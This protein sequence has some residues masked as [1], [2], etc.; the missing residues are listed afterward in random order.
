[1]NSA[2][3]NARRWPCLEFATINLDSREEIAKFIVALCDW[4]IQS[5]LGDSDVEQSP[6]PEALI[7]LLWGWDGAPK[8]RMAKL[9]WQFLVHNDS[10][11][12]FDQFFTI[13]VESISAQI[14]EA[15]AL[16][17]PIQ[18][19]LLWIIDGL[20][21]R[22][23]QDASIGQG[24]WGEEWWLPTDQASYVRQQLQRARPDLIEESS[25]Y[26]DS[27]RY[28][29]VPYF[30]LV[31]DDAERVYV[32]EIRPDGYEFVQVEDPAGSR[33][34]LTRA[35]LPFSQRP[36]TGFSWGYAGSGPCELATSILADAVGG[37]LLLAQRMR[38]DFV[39][40]VLA[41]I[42]Q[43][44]ALRIPRRDVFAWL[45]AKGVDS[46][47]LRE[48][49][50]RVA[51]L[52]ER[53]G[54]SLAEHKRRLALIRATGGLVAQRFDIV[55][56]DFECALYVDLMR[57][58]ENAGWV[59]RC[60]RCNQPLPCDRSPTGNRQRARWLA[61]RPVYHADCFT[62]HRREQKRA[63]WKQRTAIPS[64]RKQE[65]TRARNRRKSPNLEHF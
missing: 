28:Q 45:H 24:S 16:L 3:R 53:S 54:D 25:S 32:G 4:G 15:T 59:L 62:E 55:P 23:R 58:M 11:E 61:S 39:E 7:E 46:K 41:N 52:K 22:E 26:E 31:C 34:P 36:G 2:K 42:R 27:M 13:R 29:P 64:F 17:R 5:D 6:D 30:E 65:R 40:D 21:E 43:H 63:Y 51:A 35:K 20:T 33:R 57:T 18:Q 60:N 56:P 1:M 49:T 8:K 47:Q 19:K 50:E 38:D 10:D 48:A 9:L 44:T 14:P 12:H 37:D